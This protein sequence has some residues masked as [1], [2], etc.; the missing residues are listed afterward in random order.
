MKAAVSASI[1]TQL[2]AFIV[3][4]FRSFVFASAYTSALTVV[5][6]VQLGTD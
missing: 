1:E 2:K 3:Q 6:A 4:V 5:R